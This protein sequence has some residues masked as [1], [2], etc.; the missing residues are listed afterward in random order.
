MRCV[1][2]E[3]ALE[4]VRQHPAQEE[5]AK[6]EEDADPPR[7][8]FFAEEIGNEMWHGVL[9]VVQACWVPTPPYIAE[10]PMFFDPVYFLFLVPGLLLSFWAQFKVKSTFKKYAEVPSA[11]GLSGAEAA[12]ELIRHRGVSGVRIEEVSGFLS[13]HYDPAQ[14]V[15]RLSPD[16]YHGRSLSALGVAAHEAGHAI[17]HAKA[18]GP[19]KLRSYLVKP[20]NFGSSFGLVIASVGFAL[21][22]TSM[23]M[24]GVVLFSAAVLFTLVTLP[25]EF[26][27][28]RRAVVALKELGIVTAREAQGSAAVLNAAALTYVAAAVSAILQ[29]LYFL[30]RAGLMGGRREE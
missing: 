20:A 2:G 28:S 7:R 14:R 21:Q 12:A 3:G 30:F 26:D 25:V 22:A 24:V 6:G 8:D 1:A 27:A 11:R 5:G 15:L 13:D 9:S 16:V 18:Y 29:L 17:Q 23:V 10:S 4:V 19:L